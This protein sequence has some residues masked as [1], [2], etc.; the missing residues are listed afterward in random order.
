MNTNTETLYQQADD[1]DVNE[2]E[3]GLI[4]FNPETDRVHHLNPTAG[5][6]FSLCDNPIFQ[7]ALIESFNAL[8]G[9]DEDGEPSVMPVL[10]QLLEEGVLLVDDEQ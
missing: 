8:F 10:Q 4:I 2:A 5:V 7:S 3:D 1:L 9:L 6:L